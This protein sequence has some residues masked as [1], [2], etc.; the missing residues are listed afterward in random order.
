MKKKQIQIIFLFFIVLSFSSHAKI[1]TIPSPSV[2][3]FPINGPAAELSHDPGFPLCVYEPP[4]QSKCPR[5]TTHNNN[6][7]EAGCL[8]LHR[9][10]VEG[11]CRQI[12]RNTS[13]TE[14]AE[15]QRDCYVRCDAN[16]NACIRG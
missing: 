2:N 14:A 9:Q 6:K 4:R 7:H 3:S 10:C 11:C 8:E 1:I 15:R 16:Y 13:N 5:K 12:K